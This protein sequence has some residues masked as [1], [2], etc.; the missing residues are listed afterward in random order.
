MLSM[1]ATPILLFLVAAIAIYAV[2]LW[3]KVAKLEENLSG[4][5]RTLEDKR[6]ELERARKE[7]R[8]KKDELEEVRRHLQEAKA[9]LKK[10]EKDPERES[11]G[12]S[13]KQS[14]AEEPAGPVLA[15]I[16]VRVS[17]QELSNEHRITVDRLEGEI[18]SLKAQLQEVTRRDEAM[19]REAERAA[20]ALKAAAAGEAVRAESSPGDTKK[21]DEEL[22]ALKAQ[23]EVMTRAAIENERGLKKELRRSEENARHALRRAANNAQL[24]AVIKGQLELAED[25]LASY[26]LK[27]EG[28]KSIDDLK[29]DSR[30]Q[31]PRRD[32]R[33]RSDRGRRDS[34]ENSDAAAPEGAM[35]ASDVAAPEAAMVPAVVMVESDL[36]SQETQEVTTTLQRSEEQDDNDNSPSLAE[37][38]AERAETNEN[39]V[40]SS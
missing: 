7:A 24:Y 35:I 12:P 15:P 38:R 39:V 25:R 28:A 34:R 8:E 22:R 32:R 19:K 29:K 9:K 37:E 16:V 36:E 2:M 17:D 23:L 10:R 20:N 1:D 5:A 13:K 14:K 3:K 31:R 30:N 21:P 6:G 40:Q 4:E 27:Y 18:E 33:D 11:A 26:K